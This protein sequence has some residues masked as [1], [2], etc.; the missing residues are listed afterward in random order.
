M[1]E[2]DN[3]AIYTNPIFS[4]GKEVYDL[5]SGKVLDEVYAKYKVIFDTCLANPE[6]LVNINTLEIYGEK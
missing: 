1:E 3:Y 6:Q 5:Q 2:L 4:I